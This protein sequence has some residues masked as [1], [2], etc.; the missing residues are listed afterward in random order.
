M[1]LPLFAIDGHTDAQGV[2][3]YI[4]STEEANPLLTR[5]HYLGPIRSGGRLT[6]IGAINEQVLACQV[7]KLPTSRHLPND[8]TWLELARWC[9]TSQVGANAGSRMHKYA[10]RLIRDRECA[11]TL[12]SYSDPS[13]GHTGSLYRACNWVWAPQWQR[14]RP[15]PTG[16]GTWDGVTVQAPK[17][18][19][20]FH[21]TRTDAERARLYCTDAGAVR[22]W[23]RTASDVELGWARRSPYVRDLLPV[24][25]ARPLAD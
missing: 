6:V 2:T 21:V 24:T 8:G 3:W 17:D 11:R 1:T 10:A 19:W 18:R 4:G 9:L 7:W 14:L 15:P 23:L 25:P 22:H 16:G 13:V 20:V 12:V 5:A